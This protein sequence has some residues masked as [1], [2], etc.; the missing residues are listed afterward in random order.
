MSDLSGQRA[1]VTGGGSG[2]GAAIALAIAEAGASV[3]V[4]GRRMEPLE[5]MAAKSDRIS[6]VVADMTDE[7]SVRELFER[8]GA[9]H[10]YLD[11]VVANAGAAESAPFH[12][13]GM[14]LW[15][16]MLDVNLTGVFL[17][18]QNALP[19]LMKRK[20]GRLIAVAST[21]GLKGY[22]YVSAYSAAKHGVVGLTK[23]LALELAETGITVN[24]VCPGFTHTPMLERSIETIM[25]KTGKGRDEAIAALAGANPQK[26][27]VRPEEVAETVLFL[28]GPN[29]AAI[30]GQA[31]SISGGEV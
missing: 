18:F 1:L 30:T 26:R 23:S 31:I 7:A 25:Q 4:S 24:A 21:A 10:G 22:P 2:L 5:E 9:E 15:K 29:A 28:C 20:Q 13:T 8:I 16:K 12:R 19:S 6:G 14:D 11:I 17:T 27:F 3:V